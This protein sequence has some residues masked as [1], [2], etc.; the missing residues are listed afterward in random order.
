MMREF[1]PEIVVHLAG[2]VGGI[3]A[4]Q[5]NPA[6]F[7][8]NNLQMGMNVLEAAATANTHRVV[9]VG[10]VCSYPHTPP[11]IPFKE[12][13]LWMG[14]PEPTNAPY[15]I[16]KRALLEMAAQ[17]NKQ[18]GMTNISLLPVNMYGPEDDFNPATSHVIPALI[19]K[20]AIAKE[21]GDPTVELWGTGNATREFMY[22]KDFAEACANACFVHADYDDPINIGTGVEIKIRTIAQ[23]IKDIMGYD[24][25][26]TYDYS[27][28]DGQPRRCLDITRAKEWLRWKPTTQIREGLETT[29]RWYMENK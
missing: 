26:L 5:E 2:T 23:V 27:K 11:R 29:I 15:G 4:N 1:N 6:C 14:Y 22:V 28:P 16:A 24:G 7:M 12:N 17:Y 18:Y 19:R 8:Y 25:M 10:T 20:I 21:H 3:G 13:D 9:M